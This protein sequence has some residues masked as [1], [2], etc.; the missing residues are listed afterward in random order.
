MTTMLHHAPAAHVTPSGWLRGPV[1]LADDDDEMRSLIAEVL[2]NDGYEVHEAR[3]GEEL[4]ALLLAEL[5]DGPVH[6][7]GMVISDIRMPG[8]S[9]LEV[10][11]TLRACNKSMPVVLTTAFGDEATH[12]LA[13]DLG[14]EL[15]L[16]KPFDLAE[17]R[18]I[19]RI[20]LGP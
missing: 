4:W 11:K 8:C 5:E 17:L 9:G 3:N 10:L 7:P 14:A 19:V 13:E 6:R 2:R 18:M 12:A 15:L 1:L 16:D 20:L